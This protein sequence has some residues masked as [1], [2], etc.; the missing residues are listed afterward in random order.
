V[1]VNF[2]LYAVEASP[3]RKSLVHALRRKKLSG[4][5]A[6]LDAVD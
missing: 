2:I 4:S 1:E 6:G 5:G 3:Q